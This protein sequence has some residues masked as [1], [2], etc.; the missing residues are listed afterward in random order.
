MSTARAERG[1][2]LSLIRPIKF[3]RLRNSHLYSLRFPSKYLTNCSLS[4]RHFAYFI[5]KYTSNPT[6]FF[7]SVPKCDIWP[8]LGDIALPLASEKLSM[9]GRVRRAK[10]SYMLCALTC[11]QWPLPFTLL[12]R[13]FCARRSA[14]GALKILSG[15]SILGV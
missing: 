9:I 13:R 14:V 3:K 8:F 4:R 7:I 10:N 6:Q 15:I 11:W 12:A 1:T 5:K 2:H